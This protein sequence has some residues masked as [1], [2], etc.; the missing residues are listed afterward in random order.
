MITPRHD[1]GYLIVSEPGFLFM[2]SR[3]GEFENVVKFSDYLY[4]QS[5]NDPDVVKVPLVTLL[6][7]SFS[8]TGDLTALVQDHADIYHPFRTIRLFSNGTIRNVPLLD[9]AGI[10][11]KVNI[12]PVK[13]GG[14]IIIKPVYRNEPG[15]GKQILLERTND[16]GMVL[17][18]A[19]LGTC[20][21]TFCN[22]DLIDISEEEPQKFTVI[23]QSHEQSN[24][25]SSTPVTTI[26]VLVDDNG[27]VVDQDTLHTVTDMPLW[28]FR[29]GSI[30]DFRDML[31][32]RDYDV[33]TSAEESG[34]Y[35][36]HSVSVLGT[37]DGGYA[38]I[39][40]RYAE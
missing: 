39:G 34:R 1:G 37:D 11:W 40:T 17:W 38:L 14:N 30:S 28:V 8:D 25:T 6:T 23:Y 24:A 35:G 31:S 32:Q 26:R 12:R 20:A 9:P 3:Q 29:T 21:Y 33:L 27:H 4:Q 36:I 18:N 2:F 19:T 7:I 16:G 10:D 5:G 15:G 13:D 22:N